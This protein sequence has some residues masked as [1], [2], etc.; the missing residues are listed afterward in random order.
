MKALSLSKADRYQ[1]AT[2]FS[3]DVEKFQ[4]GFATEA[5]QAGL[6]KQLMLLVKR[7]KGIFSTAAAA[8][9]LI[10]GLAVWFV[11]GLQAK[12]KEMRKQALI[13]RNAEALALEK[14]A[15]TSRALARSSLSLAEAALR[16][17]NG[18]A[19]QAALAEVP[20]DLRDPTWQYLLRQSDS[21]ITR[22]DDRERFL[23]GAAHPRVPHLFAVIG[24]NADISF[25]NVRSGERY[26]RFKA[27]VPKGS[28]RFRIAISPDG[29]RIAVGQKVELGG[30]V[31]HST[32]NGGKVS[33]WDAKPTSY[34]EFSPDGRS[35]LQSEHGS[36]R[37]NLW[38]VDRKS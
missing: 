21:S 12:E 3:A 30:I 16:E 34:L 4:G 18:P 6:G 14:E 10:T 5:E 29:E 7:N 23:A 33:G 36:Q 1:E 15:E 13:A 24:Y 22:I 20:E 28:R 37:V 27:D 38:E 32:R 11:F 26:F 19:I 8:W 31:I 35:L 2:A 25:L 9:L 17:G